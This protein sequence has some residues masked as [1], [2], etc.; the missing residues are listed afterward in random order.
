MIHHVKSLIFLP[1]PTLLHSLI[2]TTHGFPKFHTPPALRA[3]LS[4]ATAE[5][6]SLLLF[7]PLDTIKTRLQA[8]HAPLMLSHYT[9]TLPALIGTIFDA[10]VFTAVYSTLRTR[11]GTASAAAT[12]SV[13]ST[14]IEV[15]FVFARDRMRL[16]LSTSVLTKG[17]IYGLILA[18]IGIMIR[19]L[20]AETIEFET[21]ERLCKRKGWDGKL[22]LI[23]AGMMAGGMAAAITAPI[24]TIV[25]RVMAGD[26]MRRIL[27][28]QGLKGLYKGAGVRVM[29]EAMASAMFF[30]VYE[31]LNGRD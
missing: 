10:G 2:C 19:D 5:L 21:Y 1:P 28:N 9:G 30:R 27:R 11:I 8:G 13:L 23:M 16:G 14:V 26:G 25:S 6:T 29:K 3:A 12:A 20:P 18:A 17:R 7:Y 31:G 4:G 22:G 24:D 15:P